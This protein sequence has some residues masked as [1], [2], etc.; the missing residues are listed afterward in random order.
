MS[1][2]CLSPYNNYGQLCPCG[3]C[4]NCRKNRSD[5]WSFRM[6][7][8]IEYFPDKNVWS[9]FITLTYDEEHVPMNEKGM[10]TLRHDDYSKYVKR[11][12][13]QLK[14]DYGETV[15][16]SIIGCGEYGNKT[17]RPHYHL[18]LHGI[19]FSWRDTWY[20]LVDSLEKKWKFGFSYIKSCNS[21]V[22]SYVTKYSL[23]DLNRRRDD[24]IAQG[25][26]PSFRVYSHG[27]GM[28]Y[29]EACKDRIRREGYCRDGKFKVSVPKYFKDKFFGRSDY[30]RSRKV[31]LERNV[32][33]LQKDG[34]LDDGFELD[35]DRVADLQYAVHEANTL[36][37]RLNKEKFM[38]LGAVS[39]DDVIREKYIVPYERRVQNRIDFWSSF[40]QC[41]YDELRKCEGY[42][43]FRNCG[44]FLVRKSYEIAKQSSY[45]LLSRGYMYK[46][47][48]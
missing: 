24:Y 41:K 35:C 28:N 5:M 18:V 30:V 27:I 4:L 29:F 39:E 26:E 31:V 21:E 36:I 19:P 22:A 33:L 7:K 13:Q 3:K 48:L 32:E 43:E 12:R 11:V 6:K 25:I 47:V 20:G 17:G 38:F 40:V 14:R 45:D 9:L 42:E 44:N 15:H 8:E 1:Y 2:R 23:K 34:V 46:G 16:L 10:L 37:N